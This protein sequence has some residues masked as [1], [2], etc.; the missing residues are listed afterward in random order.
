MQL[1]EELRVPGLFTLVLLGHALLSSGAAI[2]VN[3]T[4]EQGEATITGIS[5]PVPLFATSLKNY[6]DPAQECSPYNY[7]PVANQ[8][9]SFPAIGSKA[10]ILPNDSAA[11]DKWKTISGSIPTSIGL[12]TQP[13]GG[14]YPA[15]DPDCWWTYQQCTIPKQNGIPPDLEDA[16]EPS[17]LG[18][19]FDD[20][21]SCSHNDFLDFLQSQ[22][23]K[24]TFY[25]IGSN[26]ASYPLEAQRALA[27]GHEICIHTW[28]HPYMTTLSSEDAFAEIWYFVTFSFNCNLSM[29]PQIQMVKV[30]VGVTPTC[31]R[32][33]YG[34]IDDRIRAIA[35]ALGLQT[36]MWEY[37]TADASVNG[38]SITEDTV[39]NN[40][41]SFLQTAGSGTFNSTGT[42]LL[43]HEL[44]NFTMSEA[45]KYYS[46]ISNAF[47][48]IVP[49]GVSLN[50][51]QPYL[52]NNYSLPTFEQYISGTL[53]VNASASPITSSLSSTPS[54]T[55]G[56]SVGSTNSAS[57]VAMEFRL[58][59]VLLT[60]LVLVFTCRP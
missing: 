11:L 40:Y 37:D 53:M 6:A 4:S 55:L 23:Q 26:V 5:I 48:Y 29:S 16:P 43:M 13:P 36:I 19:G 41:I 59:H 30:A 9:N 14:D 27:D 38:Q 15:N 10:S 42:I 2:D 58:A 22:K 20:G 7:P 3:R 50:K 49:V 60:A 47:Q 57:R 52:E 1:V 51:T 46:Q 28:S 54:P 34:D 39:E 35:N 31:W 33:P 24:A 44:N 21:P 25:F 8:M 45:M 56:Q 12:K 17:T 18:Y 32:P